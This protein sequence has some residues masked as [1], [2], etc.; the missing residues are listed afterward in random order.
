M[1]NIILP[2]GQW[3]IARGFLNWKQVFVHNWKQEWG[4]YK[5]VNWLS[6]SK[7]WTS[8]S[9]NWMKMNWKYIHIKDWIQVGAEYDW[10]WASKYYSNNKSY[11]ISRI[12]TKQYI[13]EN[14]NNV[15]IFDDIYAIDNV[16][17]INNN[18][19]FTA[20]DISNNKNVYINNGKKYYNI[21]K[22]VEWKKINV[23]NIWPSWVGTNKISSKSKDNKS[24]SYVIT[25]DNWKDIIIKDWIQL[26]WEY[27]NVVK[28][29]FNSKYELYYIVKNIYWKEELYKDWVKISNGYDS[30]IKWDIAWVWILVKDNWVIKFIQDWNETTLWNYD[31]AYYI[32]TWKYIAFVAI[33]NWKYTLI[34]WGFKTREYDEI[35]N[36]IISKNW[37]NIAFSVKV[38]WDSIVVENWRESNAYWYISYMAYSPDSKTLVFAALDKAEQFIIIVDKFKEIEKFIYNYSHYNYFSPLNWWSSFYNWVNS[39]WLSFYY[40][41]NSPYSYIN[42]LKNTNNYLVYIYDDRKQKDIVHIYT[43]RKIH[44]KVIIKEN[45]NSNTVNSNTV[46]SNNN[47][48]KYKQLFEVKFKSILEN[49]P[50]S[51][52]DAISIKI[53]DAITKINNNNFSNSKDDLIYQLTALKEIITEKILNYNNIGNLIDFNKLLK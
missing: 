36:Y 20:R 5:Y 35:I 21:K 42:K 7:D 22:F 41:N 2:N 14:W 12:W 47:I 13:I 28:I 18:I 16:S 29:Q 19:T 3:T 33:K 51:R 11:F 53:D 9:F 8:V 48:E 1:D 6:Y 31:T 10:I 38:N 25:K 46:N 23:K 24:F 52:L 26:W 4:T 32:N 49:I 37:E 17:F 40:E 30:I 34:R 43:P 44:N 15:S 27:N 39:L 50:N 45:V